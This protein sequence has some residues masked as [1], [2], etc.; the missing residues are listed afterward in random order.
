MP[1]HSLRLLNSRSSR[2]VVATLLTSPFPVETME[3]VPDVVVNRCIY[4]KNEY[5]N[6]VSRDPT[7]GESVPKRP[8]RQIAVC[9]V[10]YIGIGVVDER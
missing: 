2:F 3:L 6:Y 10:R 1:F 8:Y 4:G 9:P 7:Q 5:E